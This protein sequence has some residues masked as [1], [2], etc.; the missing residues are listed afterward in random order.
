MPDFTIRGNPGA[1]RARATLT[2]DKGTLF[3]ETG[4]A[5][6][7]I[8]TEGWTGRAADHFRD[9]HDLEPDRWYRSGNGFRLA[10]GALAVYADAVE[11]AQETATWAQAE[12][13][14][15]DRASGEY[16]SW[17]DSESD[18]LNTGLANGTYSSIT[19]PVWNDPGNEI[20]SNA[21]RE[22]ES[23][24]AALDNAAQV[25]A[26]EVR[27]GCAD[28][29]EEPSWWES[30]LKFVGGIFQ[31]AGE[32]LWDIATMLP[33]SPA[34]LIQ[35][36]WKLTTG[37]LTPEELAKTYELDLETVGDMFNALR[38]DP[39][40]FGKNLGK[41]LLDW[42]TWADDPA[43]ALGH[44]VPD[45]IVAVATAGTG[46]AATRGAGSVDD[47]ADGLRAIDR[48]SDAS[49]LNRLDDL[50]D[51][52][53]L[54]DLGDVGR[55]D[56]LDDLSHLDLGDTPGFRPDGSINPEH[57]RTPPDSAYF[58]SGRSDGVGGAEVAGRYA[59]DAHG[60]TL[61]QVMERRGIEMPEWDADS[62]DVVRTWGDASAAY[63]QEANGNVHA[64][65][66][67]DLRPGNVWE[68]RELDALKDNPNVTSITRID[69]R[70]GER[71]VIWP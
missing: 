54:D 14:R 33:F 51:V 39:V 47:I 21:L 26:G 40:E 9:A 67:D 63:A 24:R 5:L 65:I 68:T 36:A 27:A 66:G 56:N 17:F 42:D 22:L 32:A 44:L 35:D 15:G 53:H 6:S 45:A 30:G 34:N 3:D 41:G 2:S 50:G 29:P 18:R 70:T 46:A 38:D 7:K 49:A 31:G 10:G 25:C 59:E 69:P 61:E 23:A 13:E 4:D 16:R 57:F 37:D 20:R 11:Q 58:W 1:I 60:T 12:H 48:V 8:D 19:L 43:R 52:R 64:V 28:A 71:E 62:P 55:L